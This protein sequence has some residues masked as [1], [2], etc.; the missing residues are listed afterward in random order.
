MRVPLS[1]VTRT[2]PSERFAA[3]TTL[4]CDADGTLFDS[5]APA[6][7]ASAGVTNDF[8]RSLGVTSSYTAEELRLATTGKNFRATAVD[9]CRLHEVEV[10][11]D[12]RPAGRAVLTPS[13]LEEWVQ[14]ERRTVTAHLAAAL[15]RDAEVDA[16]LRELASTYRLAAVSSSHTDRLHACFAATGMADLFPPSVVFSADD[17]LPQPRSKPDPAVYVL[18]GQ[19]TGCAGPSGLA[20][21]DSA[22]GAASAVGAGFPTIG[23]LQYVPLSERPARRVALVDAGVVDVVDSWT[24]LTRL[25]AGADPKERHH[26]RQT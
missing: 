14:V 15:R 18:A 13:L 17:S 12:D 2:A 20:L 11:A 1:T 22:T 3:V 9:L 7:E 16:R 5:E 19:R 6:F 25:L 8:L 10:S 26:A 24:E 21:E 4:L 23:V